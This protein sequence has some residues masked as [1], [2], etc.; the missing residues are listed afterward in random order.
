MLALVLNAMFRGWTFG[1]DPMTSDW[2]SGFACC[3]VS[4]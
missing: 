3:S 4:N 2:I 1:K